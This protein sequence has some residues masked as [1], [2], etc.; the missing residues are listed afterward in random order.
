MI[1]GAVEI[2]VNG[3]PRRH[4]RE[5]GINSLAGGRPLRRARSMAVGKRIA[6]TVVVLIRAEKL[7]MKSM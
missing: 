7:M 6:A 2:P 4:P 1:L 5:K 3:P